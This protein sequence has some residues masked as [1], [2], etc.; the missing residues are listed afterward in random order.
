MDEYVSLN[1]RVHILWQHTIHLRKISVK[2]AKLLNQKLP[3]IFTGLLAGSLGVISDR[4]FNHPQLVSTAFECCLLSIWN[5]LINLFIRNTEIAFSCNSNLKL[6]SEWMVGVIILNDIVYFRNFVLQNK[7]VLNMQ[8][9]C[10]TIISII[11]QCNCW[12]YL[13]YLPCSKYL[14]YKWQ[15]IKGVKKQRC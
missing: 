4:S 9:D 1:N 13:V 6:I 14:R 3:K 15:E 10:T 2:V 7:L 11:N 8:N 12:C 5:L